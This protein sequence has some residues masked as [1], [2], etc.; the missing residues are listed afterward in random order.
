MICQHETWDS[1][2]ILEVGRLLCQC[3]LYRC[4]PPWYKCCQL[5]FADPE[6][7]FV[8]FCRIC[9]SLNDVEYADITTCL[10]RRRWDHTILRLQ[11]SPHHVQYCSLPY[12]LCLLYIVSCE[13]SVWGHEE[14]ASRRWNERSN[15]ANEVIVHVA[16]VAKGG[17]AGGHDSGD[18]LIRLLERRLLDVKS[19]GSYPW[20][21]AVIEHDHRVCILGQPSHS[22]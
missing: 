21:S 3:D 13:G 10:T 22:E 18:E 1:V 2:R 4:R 15:N 11:Q 17:C 7:W 6:E 9:F 12:R 20:Q 14:V 16:R 19:V 5:A 8:H